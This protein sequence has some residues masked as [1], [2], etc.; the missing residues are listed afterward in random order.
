M[1]DRVIAA[2]C[3]AFVVRLTHEWIEKKYLELSGSQPRQTRIFSTKLRERRGRAQSPPAFD[4]ADVSDDH[5]RSTY[6]KFFQYLIL[7]FLNY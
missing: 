3:E 7:D 6:M 1:L 4:N 2:T 5:V